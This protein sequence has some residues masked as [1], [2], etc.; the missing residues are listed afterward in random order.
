MLGAFVLLAL[1]GPEDCASVEKSQAKKNR[2]DSAVDTADLAKENPC[3]A[4]QLVSVKG[5]PAQAFSAHRLKSYY[6]LSLLQTA[7]GAYEIYTQAPEHAGKASAA[8]GNDALGRTDMALILHPVL[9]RQHEHAEDMSV[10]HFQELANYDTTSGSGKVEMPTKSTRMPSVEVSAA[11]K[12]TKPEPNGMARLLSAHFELSDNDL[13][14]LE[15]AEDEF[16]GL[17]NDLKPAAAPLIFTGDFGCSAAAMGGEDA[18][19]ERTP[20]TLELYYAINAAKHE[21]GID[22]FDPSSLVDGVVEPD[23]YE[24]DMMDDLPAH[25]QPLFITYLQHL[26]NLSARITTNRK[27]KAESRLRRTEAEFEDN[28]CLRALL[29]AE[30][31]YAPLPFGCNPM[32]AEYWSRRGHDLDSMLDEY[33]WRQNTYADRRE[34]E[35]LTVAQ[36]KE[37]DCYRYARFDAPVSEPWDLDIRELHALPVEFTD[38]HPVFLNKKAFTRAYEA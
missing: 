6:R 20:Y 12:I 31:P 10:R 2:C 13:L 4:W 15:K 18:E 28:A 21:Y 19:A 29:L 33:F 3:R 11:A 17:W 22:E 27:W 8:P 30:N 7:T 35:W 16:D 5:R 25:L 32:I 34:D 38:D 23:C 37:M 1:L 14:L 9:G 24:A 36:E 26:S